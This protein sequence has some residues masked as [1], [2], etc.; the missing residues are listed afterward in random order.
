M[1]LAYETFKLRDICKINFFALLPEIN[2]PNFIRSLPQRCL[3]LEKLTQFIDKTWKIYVVKWIRLTIIY[4]F[5]V[6]C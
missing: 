6:K 2:L 1:K 5:F 3:W 4:E